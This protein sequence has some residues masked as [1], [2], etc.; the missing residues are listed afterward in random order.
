MYP[1]ASPGGSQPSPLL[2]M[3][4]WRP[5][6]ARGTCVSPKDPDEAGAKPRGRPPVLDRPCTQPAAG[7]A[8]PG[9]DGL[10]TVGFRWF[11]GQ[12]FAVRAA[13]ESSTGP[14]CPR[15][16]IVS[17]ILLSDHPLAVAAGHAPQRS[18]APSPAPRSPGCP[19]R[20]AEGP[21][22]STSAGRPTP[23]AACGRPGLQGQ[24]ELRALGPSTAPLPCGPGRGQPV[25]PGLLGQGR[26]DPDHPS[27][28]GP[29]PLP[30][31]LQLQQQKPL[32]SPARQRGR[33]G[34]GLLWGGG[35]TSPH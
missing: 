21:S 26:A 5:G 9:H 24:L 3:R 29:Q 20:G 14:S 19:S 32:R 16:A 11:P 27:P 12:H 8:A 31:P 18:S 22:E 25:L 23:E 28:P 15:K 13:P 30:G 1:W 2:Q 34:C 4:T 35:R 10:P 7:R 17:R 6:K 33:A